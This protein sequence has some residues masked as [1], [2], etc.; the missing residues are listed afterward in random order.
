[1]GI[2]RILDDFLREK[3]K[4]AVSEKWKRELTSSFNNLKTHRRLTKEQKKEIQEFY[5]SVIGREIDLYSHEYFY[6]RT[7]L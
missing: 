5:K 1:M 4:K 6:S 2:M 7:G 3:R